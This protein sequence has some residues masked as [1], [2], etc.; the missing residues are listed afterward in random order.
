MIHHNKKQRKFILYP[1]KV[2][3]LQRGKEITQYAL[4]NK[5]WWEETCEKHDH[6]ELIKFEE[7]NISGMQERFDSV[8]NFEHYDLALRY[9]EGETLPQEIVK[10]L[11]GGVKEISEGTLEQVYNVE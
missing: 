4:P 10:F 1:Y 9:V 7:I 3:Y 2:T 5:E 6:L 8:K 11:K